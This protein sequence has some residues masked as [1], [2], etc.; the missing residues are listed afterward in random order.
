MDFDD[1]IPDEQVDDEA[2]DRLVG[3]AAGDGVACLQGP[4]Q[5]PFIQFVD[6]P[7]AALVLQCAF[8]VCC[9]TPAPKASSS[10]TAS[11][12]ATID[13]R[14]ALMTET[15]QRRATRTA[16]CGGESDADGRPNEEKLAEFIRRNGG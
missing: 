4:V 16:H 2:V 10:V 13:G 6:R 1:A 5:R 3:R 9:R 14:T 11:G 15:V 7:R 8:L 12:A